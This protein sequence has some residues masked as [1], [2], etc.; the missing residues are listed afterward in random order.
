[1]FRLLLDFGV[2]L[3]H[4]RYL[5]EPSFNSSGSILI[6]VVHNVLEANI[7]GGSARV[8]S[9]TEPLVLDASSSTDLDYEQINSSSLIFT[10]YCTMQN[11]SSCMYQNGSII[12]IPPASKV[13]F[14]AYSLIHDSECIPHII[15]DN[16]YHN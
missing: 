4:I 14:G 9:V 1:M 6:S 15:Q 2:P 13:T 11:S 8:V 5:A 3:K 12:D 10:W 16:I 7:A